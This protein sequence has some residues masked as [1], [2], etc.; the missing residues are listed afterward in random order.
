[1]LLHLILLIDLFLLGVELRVVRSAGRLMVGFFALRVLET[2]LV[3]WTSMTQCAVKR[4][5][6]YFVI[7]LSLTFFVEFFCT[8]ILL[9]I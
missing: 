2:W 5:V 7:L 9:H 4:L 8:S 6:M 1:M 3:K